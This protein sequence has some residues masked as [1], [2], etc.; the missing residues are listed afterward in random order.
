M[1]HILNNISQEEK[2]RILE[3]HRGGKSIDTTRFKA[4]LESKSGNVKPLIMERPTGTQ[5]NPSVGTKPKQAI[6]PAVTITGTKPQQGT[7]YVDTSNWVKVI[8]Y[9]DEAATQ[10]LTNI[11]IDPQMI[12]LEGNNVKFTYKVAGKNGNGTGLFDCNS[13][14]TMQFDG[15]PLTGT[16]YISDARVDTLKSKCGSNQGYASTNPVANPVANP[17][18]DKNFA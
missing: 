8:A 9:S 18:V 13:K 3:Q 2:N 12:G 16:M 11:Q 7:E 1:K 14:N 10:A 6:T 15:K 4:L 17:V 5:P